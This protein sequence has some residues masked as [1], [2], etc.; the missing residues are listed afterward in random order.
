MAIPKKIE[1]GPEVTRQLAA[2][3]ARGVS[4]RD[5]EIEFGFSRPVINRVLAS[6][7]ARDIIVNVTRDDLAVELAMNRRALSE[8]IPG[9][10]VKLAEKVQAGDIKSIEL[11]LR[12]SGMLTPLTEKEGDKQGQILQVILPGNAPIKD[13]ISE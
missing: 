7:A 13:V 1:V 6:D 9:A 12:G 2:R 5:L 11:V 8:L 10:I 3:R 4:L